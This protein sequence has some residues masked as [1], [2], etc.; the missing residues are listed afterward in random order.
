MGRIVKKILASLLFF[1]LFSSTYA[2]ACDVENCPTHFECQYGECV[3]FECDTNSPISDWGALTCSEGKEL[4]QRTFRDYTSFP[5]CEA[6]NITQYQLVD[7]QRCVLCAEKVFVGGKQMESCL[8]DG[9]MAYKAQGI[10]C[11]ITNGEK[12]STN[13]DIL[14]YEKNE[15]C[16]IAPLG[17][18]IA[19]VFKYAIFIIIAIFIFFIF[20]REYWKRGKKR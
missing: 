4:Q 1:A 5:A 3:R 12:M 19:I 16:T 13:V 20:S 2:I 9:R 6:F 10:G 8:T 7:A 14:T 17:T 15:L 11:A 18:G